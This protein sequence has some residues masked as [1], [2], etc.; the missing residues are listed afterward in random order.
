MCPA[1][2]QRHM[3]LSWSHEWYKTRPGGQGSVLVVKG[4][5]RKLS[6]F[7]ELRIDRV[8]YVVAVVSRK[9]SAVLRSGICQEA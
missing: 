8:G 4:R 3:L 7:Q 1:R 9:G 2:E 5:Q 6:S